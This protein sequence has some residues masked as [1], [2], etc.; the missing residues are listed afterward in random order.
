MSVG[1]LSTDIPGR[2]FR[3]NQNK[4][5]IIKIELNAQP[6]PYDQ[7]IFEYLNHLRFLSFN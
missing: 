6:L 3:V 7:S 2:A 5:R 4:P 1:K